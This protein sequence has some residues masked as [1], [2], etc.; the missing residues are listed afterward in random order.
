MLQSGPSRLLDACWKRKTLRRNDFSVAN[1]RL[2]V[3]YLHS[4]WMDD[5]V[6][7]AAL[8]QADPEK[9][10]IAS[11]GNQ[12]GESDGWRHRQNADGPVVGGEIPRERKTGG[13][14]EPGLSGDKRYER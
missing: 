8:R 14:F 4:L 2:I 10:A 12:R 5:A 9:G 6:S 7:R 11:A 3:A 13:H 1:P